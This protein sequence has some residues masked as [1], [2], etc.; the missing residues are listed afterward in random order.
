MKEPRTIV[1]AYSEQIFEY[2]MLSPLV[3]KC[4][5]EG[6]PVCLEIIQKAAFHL[7]ELLETLKKKFKTNQVKVALL[8]GII[9]ANTI[10]AKM[11]EDSIAVH[12]NFKRIEAKGSA[13]DGAM[14]S[15]NKLF[16]KWT[17]F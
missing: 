3:M 12:P 13:L 15:G 11:L 9:E 16:L 2:Y 7:M 6:D 10:L 5:E 8:G 14:L 4:A 17:N 1:K